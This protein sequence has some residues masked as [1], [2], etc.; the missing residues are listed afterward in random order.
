MSEIF[1]PLQG[2]RSGREFVNGGGG[3][4]RSEEM[5]GGQWQGCEH[6][7]ER[8]E[9]DVEVLEEREGEGE[10]VGKEGESHESG[11]QDMLRIEERVS[12]LA[13]GG[14]GDEDREDVVGG[15]GCDYVTG[16]GEGDQVIGED[17]SVMGGCEGGLVQE[18]CDRDLI[19]WE[20]ESVEE[21]DVTDF[22]TEKRAEDGTYVSDQLVNMPNIELCSLQ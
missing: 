16:S 20:T 22:L 9:V 2:R 15:G 3:G 5:R 12:V 10:G 18:E 7:E 1:A 13:C 11:L 19:T 4:G 21:K 8:E 6:E 14:G 17:N